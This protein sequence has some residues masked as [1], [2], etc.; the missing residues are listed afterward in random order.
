LIGYCKRLA[1]AHLWQLTDRAAANRRR[2]YRERAGLRSVA[3]HD[4]YPEEMGAFRAVVDWLLDEFPIATPEDADAVFRGVNPAVGRDR[5]LL[6]FDDGLF[7]NHAAAELLASRGVRA[8]FFI[9]PSFVDRTLSQYLDYHRRRGVEPYPLGRTARRSIGLTRTQV[10]EMAAMGHRIAAHN[11]AHRDL[12]RLHNQADLDY[13]IGQALDGVGQILGQPCR[14]FAF[15]FGQPENLSPE[16]LDRLVSSRLQVYAC[17][18]GLNV[19]GITPRFLMRHGF[20]Y[21]HPPAFTRLSLAG[22][23][24]HTVHDR[25]VRLLRACGALPAAPAGED[26][27]SSADRR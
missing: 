16:A 9:V 25:Q 8:I 17:F 2:L 24:D 18:R 19:P 13:E 21:G 15:G 5:M 14:D 4:T 12:G 10:L 6:T 7:T 27:R 26:A 3:F 1:A 23:A 20:E 22:G 11:D